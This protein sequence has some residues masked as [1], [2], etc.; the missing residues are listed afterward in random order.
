MVMVLNVTVIW[1]S[2][3]EASDL[4]LLLPLLILTV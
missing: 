2:D 1:C 4:L 3:L